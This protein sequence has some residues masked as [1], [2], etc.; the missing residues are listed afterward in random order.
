MAN[1]EIVPAVEQPQRR[2]DPQPL[3]REVEQVELA[4][5]EGRLDPAPLV[6]VL[7]GVEEP[8]AHA[9]RRQ[10]VDLVL[11]QRDERGDDDADALAHERAGSGSTATCRRRSA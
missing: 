5:E 10:R 3:G 8:G 11:H 2:L 9:E 1:S 6:E 4:R 7:R